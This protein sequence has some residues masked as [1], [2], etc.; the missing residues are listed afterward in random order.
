MS[1]QILWSCLFVNCIPLK[2]EFYD[3]WIY[4]KNGHLASEKKKRDL[5]FF[6]SKYYEYS[7]D[8]MQVILRLGLSLLSV[9]SFLFQYSLKATFQ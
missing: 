7:G 3:M 2:D 6:F 4:F 5:C 1:S 9:S 8:K